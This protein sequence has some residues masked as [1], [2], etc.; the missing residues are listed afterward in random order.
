MQQIEFIFLRYFAL[1]VSDATFTHHQEPQLYKRVWCNC[2]SR[3]C[4][5]AKCVSDPDQLY[6]RCESEMSPVRVSD[7]RT[8]DI[9]DSHLPY[10]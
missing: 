10:S 8:G 6:G 1:H 9:S 3:L 4:G 5:W 2:I 7:T